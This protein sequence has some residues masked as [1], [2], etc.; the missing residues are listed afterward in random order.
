MAYY[1]SILDS[2]GVKDEKIRRELHIIADMW[3]SNIVSKILLV[4]SML[5]MS[6]LVITSEDLELSVL[7]ITRQHFREN[8]K[9]HMDIIDLKETHLNISNSRFKM[10]EK[11]LKKIM[12]SQSFNRDFII[13]FDHI[14]HFLIVYVKEFQ[15]KWPGSFLS[16]YKEIVLF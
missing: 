9:Q 11:H 12:G 8:L 3:S 13:T 5:R 4:N 1:S 7:Y 14:I 6:D 16:I 15:H 10:V 2:Q